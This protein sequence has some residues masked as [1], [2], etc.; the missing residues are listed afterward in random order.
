MLKVLV[1]SVNIDPMSLT[2]CIVCV[3]VTDSSLNKSTLTSLPS[4]S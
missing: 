4:L 1:K 3:I 2:F